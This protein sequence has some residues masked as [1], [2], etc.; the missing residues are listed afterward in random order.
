MTPRDKLIENIVDIVYAHDGN[1]GN[2]IKLIEATLKTHYAIGRWVPVSERLPEFN[3]HEEWEGCMRW[4]Y[5]NEC[6]FGQFCA[7]HFKNGLYT[8]WLDLQMPEVES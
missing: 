7:Q 5:D 8:H 3:K 1:M 6:V 4:H 2:I